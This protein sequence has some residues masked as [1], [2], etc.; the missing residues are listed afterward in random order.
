MS[1]NSRQGFRETEGYGLPSVLRSCG[2]A[3]GKSSYQDLGVDGG[4]SAFGSSIAF[5]VGSDIVP[6]DR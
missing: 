6:N 4:H 2:M 3:G 5:V 1:G